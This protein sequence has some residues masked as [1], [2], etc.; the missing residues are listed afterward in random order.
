[1]GRTDNE[2]H[3]IDLQ[4]MWDRLLAIVEEQA[5][6]IIRTAF[7]SAVR[8]A[9]DLSAGVFDTSG[10][11]LAQAVTGTPGHVN[12]MAQS[13]PHFIERFPVG[14]MREGDVF[15]TNDPW[16]A[17]GHLHDFTVVTPCFYNNRVVAICAATCHVVDIGGRGFGADARE[18][19]EEG[20]CIPISHFLHAGELNDTLMSIIRA[21]VREPLLVEGDLHSLV[22]CNQRGAQRLCEMLREFRLDSLDQLADRIILQSGKAMQDAIGALPQGRFTHRIRI[23]GYEQPL[24]L[25]AAM[26]IRPDHISVDLSGSSPASAYGINVPLPYTSAYVCYGI[27]CLVGAGI[28]NNAGSLETIKVSAP[29]GCLLNAARPAPVS[30]RGSIGHL[31]PDLLFGCLHQVIPDQVPAES[32]S[33][34]WGPMLYGDSGSTPFSLVNA[35]AGGMGAR[36][37][38]DGLSTTGFP[39]GVRCTPVEVTETVAPVVIWRKELLA[40]SGGAGKFRGGLGQVME[41]GHVNDASFT[42]S[43]MFERVQNPAAGRDHGQAGKAGKLYTSGGTILKAK[44]Q[45]LIPAGEHLILEMPGGGGVGNPL[46]RDRELVR[47]EIAD[48]LVSP[49]SAVTVYGLTPEQCESATHHQA[50]GHKRR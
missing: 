2:L 45:Q 8:E 9:G 7:S 15:I 30:A 1:M 10:R 38:I 5:Q 20:I 44:G 46:E 41:Y 40:D 24:T 48:E 21:N 22:A 36:P 49:E 23:D 29:A 17:T 28:P 16:L 13:V 19:F 43:A 31:L 39:S 37:G 27:R 4:I 6:T 11:M 26:H 42:L 33:C 12:A 34:I 47:N 50:G 18:V 32:A 3:V 35:H 14:G 25:A